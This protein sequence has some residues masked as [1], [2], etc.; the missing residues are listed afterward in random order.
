ML[1]AWDTPP[2]AGIEKLEFQ[3]NLLHNHLL[4]C[5]KTEEYRADDVVVVEHYDVDFVVGYWAVVTD[6]HSKALLQTLSTDYHPHLHI[7]E[8]VVAGANKDRAAALDGNAADTV[9]SRGNVVVALVL[10]PCTGGHAVVVDD[11]CR[12]I[13]DSVVVRIDARCKQIDAVMI[14]EHQDAAADAPDTVILMDPEAEH[15]TAAFVAPVVDYA[16]DQYY[17]EMMIHPSLVSHQ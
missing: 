15:D 12:Q 11:D 16:S 4:P 8:V 2:P 17:Y 5:N 1:V 7:L 3:H 10:R 13:D 6:D 14:V 9:V